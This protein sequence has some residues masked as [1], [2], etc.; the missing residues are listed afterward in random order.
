MLANKSINKYTPYSLAL[1]RCCYVCSSWF[2][3]AVSYAGDNLGKQIQPG[4]QCNHKLDVFMSLL[5][6]LKLILNR[7][8]QAMRE[9][10]YIWKH[11][12][13]NFSGTRQCN[14]TSFP[15]L[16]HAPD[17]QLPHVTNLKRYVIYTNIGTHFNCTVSLYLQG[18]N[19]SRLFHEAMQSRSLTK[20]ALHQPWR[21]PSLWA[22]G[23][24]SDQCIYLSWRLRTRQGDFSPMT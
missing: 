10:G 8:M 20:G 13:C 11:Q 3:F 1:L 14:F 18:K 9:L 2:L 23:G 22:T 15:A 17:T 16:G 4:K 5:F 7:W 19:R 24:G 6:V 21:S 12:C